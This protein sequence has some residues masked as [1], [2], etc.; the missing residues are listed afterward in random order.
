MKR[1]IVA[2]HLAARLF[3]AEEAVDNTLAAMGE[4]IAAMPRA[5]LDARLSAGVG[6]QAVDHVM[7]A[8]S[9]LADVRRSLIAAHGALSEAKDQIGLRRVTLVGGGD[10]ADSDTPRTGQLEVVRSA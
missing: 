10:K 8:A 9:N 5:R 1:R 4:L 7:E 3:T 6:Q 2:E